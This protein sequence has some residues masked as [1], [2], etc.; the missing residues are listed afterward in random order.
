MCLVVIIGF[1]QE[2]LN[3]HRKSLFMACKWLITLFNEKHHHLDG[4][5][6]LSAGAYSSSSSRSVGNM[7]TS[8]S[9]LD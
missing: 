3:M 2:P 7:T 8:G 1:F 6:L 5:L 4:R 9:L